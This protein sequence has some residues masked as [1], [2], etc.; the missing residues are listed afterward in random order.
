MGGGSTQSAKSQGSS[1]GTSQFT[2]NPINLQNPAFTNLAGPVANAIYYAMA[3]P[4]PGSNFDVSG[5][6]NISPYTG[7][8]GT[9]S[10]YNFKDTANNPLVAGVTGQQSS[11]LNQ[12]GGQVSPGNPANNAAYG[13]AGTLAAAANNPLAYIPGFSTQGQAAGNLMNAA[14]N[15]YAYGQNAADTATNYAYGPNFGTNQAGNA[16]NFANGA[17]FGT[18]PA[19]TAAS[20]AYGNNFGTGTARQAGNVAGTVLGNAANPL[21]AGINTAMTGNFGGGG[22]TAALNAARGGNF[23]TGAANQAAQFAGANQNLAPATAA[24]RG[25]M[26]PNFARNLA[27]NPFTQSVVSAAEAPIIN[28]FNTQTVPG[29]QGMFTAA[30]QRTAPGAGTAGGSSAFDI[31]GANAMS[32]LEANLGNT[33]ASIYNPTYQTGIGIQAAAPGQFAALQGQKLAGMESAAQTQAQTQAQQISSLDQ[34]ALAKLQTTTGK[35]AAQ[36]QAAAA[37][38]T[39]TAQEAQALSQAAGVQATTGSAQA[40]ALTGAAGALANTASAR[41]GAM[42]GAAGALTTAG[43]AQENALQGAAASERATQQ[44]RDMASTQAAGV[45]NAMAA[46]DVGNLSTA[47]SVNQGVSTGQL[48]N[49]INALNAAALPQM[50]QQY[51]I[52]QG[53]SLYQTQVN[54]LLTAMGLGSQAAQPS[55][56][57]VANGFGVST[58]SNN[59]SSSGK[60]VSIQ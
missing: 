7:N 33:A 56:G 27:V 24:L 45:G 19:E 34:A 2:S 59:G 1:S 54:Q 13:A 35:S 11:L 31:A 25:E 23:G 21:I 16:A 6:N 26:A 47:A 46:Q 9:S 10:Q 12:V 18:N 57:N 15:P 48:N 41:A 38:G 3:N 29:L 8:V 60:G 58:S 43:T 20:Y 50:T 49:T 37:A 55:I 53:L 39:L 42:T 36:L 28:A 4:F 52:N 17:D 30:G 51:G 22:A 14:G 5:N 32:G 40:G 44:A